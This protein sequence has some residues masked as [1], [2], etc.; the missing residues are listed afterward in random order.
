MAIIKH[1][2]DDIEFIEQDSVVPNTRAGD[3]RAKNINWNEIRAPQKDEHGEYIHSYGTTAKGT[4]WATR[5][6]LHKYSTQMKKPCWQ[7]S[8]LQNKRCTHANKGLVDGVA[9]TNMYFPDPFVERYC[10]SFVFSPSARKPINP[11]TAEYI[12]AEKKRETPADTYDKGYSLADYSFIE[13]ILT[14]CADLEALNQDTKDKIFREI[15][16]NYQAIFREAHN[17]H[18]VEHQKNNKARQAA[19]AWLI[20]ERK[21]RLDILRE[22]GYYIPEEGPQ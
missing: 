5:D 10:A 14:E 20:K 8:H 3:V 7:C 13:K 12:A 4:R 2:D 21:R 15:M 18:P 16:H 17:A 22:K 11:H 19:N 6:F 1:G 9:T